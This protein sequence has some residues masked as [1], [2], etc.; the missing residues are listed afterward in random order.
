MVSVTV[1]VTV[2]VTI[3]V[4]LTAV[5]FALPVTST[6]ISVSLPISIPITFAVTFAVAV[7]IAMAITVAIA[8]SIP[9]SFPVAVSIPIPIPVPLSLP[10]PVAVPISIATVMSVG[11]AICKQTL[12]HAG[13]AVVEFTLGDGLPAVGLI[14]VRLWGAA[15][16]GAAYTTTVAMRPL[17]SL[18]VT[19]ASAVLSVA[20]PLAVAVRLFFP[21]L[22]SPDILLECATPSILGR[23]GLELIALLEA[24]LNLLI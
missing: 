19:V 6:V 23:N 20:A 14:Q 2:P 16:S 22:Q 18:L 24:R 3:P 8:V 21:L 4:A 13:L 12:R 9:L 10:V 15:G 1:S 7:S 11:A 17:T 5:A